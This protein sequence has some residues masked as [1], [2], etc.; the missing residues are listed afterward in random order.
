M[1]LDDAEYTRLLEEIETDD[2]IEQK[3]T[4]RMDWE[5]RH[6]FHLALHYQND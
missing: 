1:R 5:R 2:I 4:I 3:R 6:C